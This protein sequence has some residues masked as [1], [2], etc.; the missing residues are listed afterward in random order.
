MKRFSLILA[1]VALLLPN[2]VFAA[3]RGDSVAAHRRVAPYAMR[4]GASVAFNAGLTELL[5][6]SI[7]EMRPDRSDNDSW[8]SRHTSWAFNLMSVAA[9]ELY[10]YSGWWVVGA[11]T[12]ANAVAVQRLL[13]GN[14]FPKDVL[15][16]AAVG[17]IS[18]EL[19]YLLSDLIFPGSRQPLP[20]VAS[21]FLPT[22]DATTTALFPL[23]GGAEGVSARTGMNTSIRSSLPLSDCFGVTAA[24]NMR[25][26]P[27]Y[28]AGQYLTHLDAIGFGAG[29]MGSIEMPWRRWSAEARLMPG[30][31]H[32]FH[33]EGV[34][35][36]KVSFTIDITA[37]A[38]CALTHSTSVGFEAGYHYWALR[39]AVS[40]L[41]V[42]AFT[43][44]MF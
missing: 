15:G 34:S 33:G 16:G 7:H 35:H 11:H 43:R 19:G 25:S 22:L 30:F 10:G 14:H 20:Y 8:P 29:V 36:P 42:G 37:S 44:V 21:D 13:S 40:A 6:S 12:A 9:H 18:T 2:T 41:S 3:E 27:M 17:I 24:V 1:L 26:M 4:I 32:N 38:A 39:D 31:L 23:T 28:A 5:K